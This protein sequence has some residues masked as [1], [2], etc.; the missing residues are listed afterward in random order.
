MSRLNIGSSIS[1][2][3]TVNAK[4][5][6]NVI[7]VATYSALPSTGLPNTI[8]I[9]DATINSY[10]WNGSSWIEY[11][12]NPTSM[13]NSITSSN[14]NLISIGGTSTNPILQPQIGVW[15]PASFLF[16]APISG[17]NQIS[18]N[19]TISGANQLHIGYNPNNSNVSM[20]NYY[21]YIRN[22]LP[23]Y[24]KITD[25]ANTS[26]YVSYKINSWLGY[27]ANAYV[28]SVSYISAETT[29]SGSSI[30]TNGYNYNVILE[31][32]SGNGPVGP[33]G[34]TGAQGPTGMTGPTGFNSGLRAIYQ[35]SGVQDITKNV[36]TTF[37][38]AV[39]FLTTQLPNGPCELVFDVSYQGTVDV[40]IP[41]GTY[42]LPTHIIFIGLT[43]N[44]YNG[45][46]PNLVNTGG[47]VIFNSTLL[48]I[49]F[50]NILIGFTNTT[51]SNFTNV[52]AV[53]S[54]DF[55]TFRCNGN[56]QPIFNYVNF[57]GQVQT[58]Q[59]SFFWSSASGSAFHSDGLQGLTFLLNDA[60]YIE[61]NMITCP[62]QSS[63]VIWISTDCFIDPSYNSIAI[64][65]NNGNAINVNYTPASAPNWT[66]H[67]GSVPTL[68]SGAL[69]LVAQ[70]GTIGPTGPSGSTGPVGPVGPTGTNGANGATG[71]T[72]PQGSNQTLYL[73]GAVVITTTPTITLNAV[74]ITTLYPNIQVVGST[75]IINS[76]IVISG[77]LELND[78]SKFAVNGDLILYGSL[79]IG[80]DTTF[81]A[82]EMLC[83]G[84]SNS[85]IV[86]IQGTTSTMLMTIFGN[87]TF[88]NYQRQI[89]FTVTT[90]SLTVNAKDVYFYNNSNIIDSN[91]I[92]LW[93]N[94]SGY[95]TFNCYSFILENNTGTGNGALFN[96]GHL[97]LNADIVRFVNNLQSGTGP[98]IQ[99][100]ASNLVFIDAE[101]VDFTNNGAAGGNDGVFISASTL[102]ADNLYFRNNYS[103]GAVGPW[104]G[105]LIANTSTISCDI[106]KVI[107]DGSV[108]NQNINSVGGSTINGLTSGAV[109][110]IVFINTLGGATIGGFPSAGYT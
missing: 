56:V 26:Q 14:N 13:I 108:N 57:G 104:Y 10:I 47:D 20:I 93:G 29:I 96:V 31:S 67:F 34:P 87:M 37:A 43:C 5:Y 40:D 94:G 32:L 1:Y 83:Q 95:V 106:L 3:D 53:F 35:P 77:S 22:H 64:I 66:T 82:K 7:H 19:G 11:T 105:V 70:S 59:S 6:Q 44:L 48:E 85:D 61:P 97:N 2:I 91:T 84:T 74:D 18:T 21:D 28:F 51:V 63:L 23:A 80:E 52:L 42:T 12:E 33:I 90:G 38:G 73:S 110:H 55:S 76:N 49:K 79:T 68:V 41:A 99:L 81:Q 15:Q 107:Q 17:S 46:V 109:P 92:I 27:D 25:P 36:Y 9:D 98:S 72:G 78:S 30:L 4:K 62:T 86:T 58:S 101:T 69:D 65:L 54:Y 24:I 103:T 50:E 45:Q 100:G 71:A 16:N 88:Q 89:L 102:K 75:I 39:N 8:Y 60:T